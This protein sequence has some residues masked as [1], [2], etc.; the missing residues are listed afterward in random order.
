MNG[1]NTGVHT[2]QCTAGIGNGTPKL[3]NKPQHAP[4]L[5]L[6]L[7]HTAIT[8]M[9]HVAVSDAEEAAQRAHTGS[10]GSVMMVMTFDLQKVKVT[11]HLK[12]R[13]PR[14][15]HIQGLKLLPFKN[16]RNPMKINIFS[17]PDKNLGQ[18][19]RQTD[20]QTDG[21]TDGQTDGA[22][23]NNTPRAN[24][25]RGVKTILSLSRNGNTVTWEC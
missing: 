2:R 17:T 3:G 18:T 15:A 19:D 23:D 20:R 7:T 12:S 21:R 4:P 10:L 16:E 11:G 14:Q 9:D 22:D 5:R 6:S 25:G 24:T 1:Y 13:N 8:A